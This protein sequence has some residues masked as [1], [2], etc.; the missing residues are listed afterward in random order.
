MRVELARWPLAAKALTTQ[1]WC[2]RE[3]YKQVDTVAYE[4]FWTLMEAGLGG[5]ESIWGR[6]GMDEL[7]GEL[8]EMSPEIP[9]IC[10]LKPCRGARR[11]P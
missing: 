11:F 7:S 3:V 6:V 2:R 10:G 4:D 1:F 5:T 8:L 9:T